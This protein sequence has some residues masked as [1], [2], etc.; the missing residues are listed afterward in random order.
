MFTLYARAG[1]GSVL[2]EA[3]LALYDLPY[4][5]EE[6]GDLFKDKAAMDALRPTNPI[7]QLPTLVTNGVL[8]VPTVTVLVTDVLLALALR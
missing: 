5:L 7:T 3:Q 4:R 8:Y 2:A 1:W 6:V